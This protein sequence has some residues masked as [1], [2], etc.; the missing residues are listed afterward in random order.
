MTTSRTTYQN[1]Y[2]SSS[3]S[4]STDMHSSWHAAT[5]T[6]HIT[7]NGIN[8][9]TANR[10]TRPPP[11]TPTTNGHSQQRTSHHNKADFY[12]NGRPAEVI[13]IDSQSPDPQ[14]IQST[15][16][17]KRQ[18][19]ISASTTVSAVTKRARKSL[20]DEISSSANNAASRHASKQKSHSVAWVKDERGVYRAQN[21]IVPKI[22]EVTLTIPP[23][24]L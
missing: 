9:V 11:P 12:K 20:N 7:T 1:N 4:V 14:S 17:R 22:E 6:S 5:Y 19:S 18:D 8:G 21:V 10:S 3:A 23:F 13:V 24:R 2:P 15:S 16:K